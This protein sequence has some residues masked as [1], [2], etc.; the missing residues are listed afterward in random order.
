MIVTKQGEWYN[1]NRRWHRYYGPAVCMQEPLTYKIV[2]KWFL[3][4]RFVKKEYK[5]NMSVPATSK[6]GLL[7]TYDG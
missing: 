5:D 6:Y 3:D 2:G 1:N 4:G 7:F